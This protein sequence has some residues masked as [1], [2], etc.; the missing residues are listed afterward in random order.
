MDTTMVGFLETLIDI[1][2]FGLVGNERWW[3]DKIGGICKK[4]KSVRCEV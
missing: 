2:M 4:E 3:E 1:A